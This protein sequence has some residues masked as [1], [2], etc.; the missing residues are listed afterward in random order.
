[1]GGEIG[2]VI[3]CVGQFGFIG[4]I[5]YK[6][7]N[8]KKISEKLNEFSE[9]QFN[10]LIEKLEPSGY[11]F[12][13]N[14]NIILKRNNQFEE[15]YKITNNTKKLNKIKFIINKRKIIYDK[16]IEL[17]NKYIEEYPDIS[18]YKRINLAYKIAII[19]DIW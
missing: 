18:Y 8:C 10:E 14:Y 4:Y 9:K 11:V 19:E 1:M 6:V 16:L 17:N 12:Y 3:A 5:S 13:T 7:Y 2:G 15:I